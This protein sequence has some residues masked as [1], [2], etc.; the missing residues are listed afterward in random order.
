MS[1]T[2]AITSW[3]LRS[4]RI[5]RHQAAGA[6]LAP[7]IFLPRMSVAATTGRARRTTPSSSNK[8]RF[9]RRSRSWKDTSARSSPITSCKRADTLDRGRLTDLLAVYS[10]RSFELELTKDDAADLAGECLRQIG[11]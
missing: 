8:A 7:L 5:R 1:A 3:Q 9:W 2:A 11:D 6:G 4:T 10:L